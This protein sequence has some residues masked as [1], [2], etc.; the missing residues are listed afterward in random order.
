MKY[1]KSFEKRKSEKE[2]IDDKYKGFTEKISDKKKELQDIEHGDDVTEIKTV[3]VRIKK[4]EIEMAEKELE[5]IKLRDKKMQFKKDLKNVE[6]EK[7]KN[8]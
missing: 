2:S 8:D 4:V 5:I 6:K 3:R 1:L 7:K